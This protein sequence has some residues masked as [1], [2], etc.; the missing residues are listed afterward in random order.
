[1]KFSVSVPEEVVDDNRIRSKKEVEGHQD[2]KTSRHQDINDL[3]L[4]SH[5]E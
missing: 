1:M 2:I 5:N 4:L 3:F